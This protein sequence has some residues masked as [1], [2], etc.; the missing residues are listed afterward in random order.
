MKS[1]VCVLNLQEK[2]ILFFYTKNKTV[3]DT[4]ILL[5]NKNLYFLVAFLIFEN[6]CCCK[7]STCKKITLS[8]FFQNFL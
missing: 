5:S 2:D 3:R 7:S 4:K 8:F 6:F 1:F